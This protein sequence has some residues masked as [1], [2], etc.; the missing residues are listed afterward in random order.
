MQTR[1]SGRVTLSCEP[2]EKPQ[3]KL[4]PTDYVK[5]QAQSL[6]ER[7]EKVKALALANKS[8]AE[9]RDIMNVSETVIQQDLTRMGIKLRDLR[10]MN[11]RRRQRAKRGEAV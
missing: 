10:P 7:R 4:E 6:Q 1:R 2:W 5:S 11:R 9:I 8:K 3:P